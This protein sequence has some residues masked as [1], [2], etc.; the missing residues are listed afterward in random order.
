MALQTSEA[1]AE[2]LR[3]F[4]KVT[5]GDHSGAH[6]FQAVC[7]LPYIGGRTSSGSRLGLGERIAICFRALQMSSVCQTRPA[8]RCRRASRAKHQ[9]HVNAAASVGEAPKACRPLCSAR[10]YG[11]ALL[12]GQV[13]RGS[14]RLIPKVVLAFPYRSP[15]E[16]EVC[17]RW[18]WCR[19]PWAFRS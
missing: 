11:N 9:A 1:F 2:C 10:C 8:R 18:S 14:G 6:S 7:C 19:S 15:E 13:R 17:G 4:R 3:A 16:I 5:T 12:L